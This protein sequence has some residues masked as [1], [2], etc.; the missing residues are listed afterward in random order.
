MLFAFVDP[1]LL[2]ARYHFMDRG[3]VAIDILYE[4]SD[5]ALKIESGFTREWCF[6][7]VDKVDRNP[8]YHIRHF[9]EA[10]HK[11]AILELRG[12]HNGIVR[13][14]GDAG[15]GGCSIL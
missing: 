11:P 1:D 9:A 14:K 4:G 12:F 7:F 3:A 8:M 15:P 10:S 13:Q 5:P 2:A 6:T